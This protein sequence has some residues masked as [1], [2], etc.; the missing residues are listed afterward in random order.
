MSVATEEAAEAAIGAACRAL[1]RGSEELVLDHYL[2]ILTRKPGAMAGSTPLAKARAAGTF[3]ATHEAF[4]AAAR[5]RL[6]DGAGTRA[7]I[8][9]LLLHRSLP[10]DAVVAGM[11]GALAISSVDPEVVAV[12]ARRSLQTAAPAS[13]V[14]IGVALAPRPAP[15]LAGYD[16]LLAG[17]AR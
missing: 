12:E 7:L 5:R 6:G 2:E 17:G 11:D 10:A 16:T 13:V 9:V 14:P 8:G 15:T 3:G 4:W 1:H